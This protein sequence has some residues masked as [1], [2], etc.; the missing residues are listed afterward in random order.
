MDTSGLIWHCH[1]YAK[2]KGWHCEQWVIF[3]V[4]DRY[5]FSFI[6]NIL[7]E[8]RGAGVLKHFK[9]YMCLKASK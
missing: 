4:M 2:C 8:T 3:M 1:I 6:V 7:P 5:K 9:K